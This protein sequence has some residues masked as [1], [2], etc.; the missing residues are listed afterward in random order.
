MPKILCY[1]LEYE[2][3]AMV[4]HGAGGSSVSMSYLVLSLTRYTAWAIEAEAILAARVS[5]RPCLRRVM[6]RWTGGKTRRRRHNFSKL[7]L[8]TS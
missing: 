1:Y 7:C 3:M 8:R 2:S 4:P 5:G 6:V